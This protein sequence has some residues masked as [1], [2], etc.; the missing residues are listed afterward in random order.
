VLLHFNGNARDPR[1]HT[2]DY[3]PGH[4]VYRKATTVVKDVPAKA[5]ETVIQVED[6]RDFRVNAGRYRTSNDDLALFRIT[7]DGKHDWRYGEQV[8]LISAD[9]EANTITA[10]RGCYGTQPLRFEAGRP[11][12]GLPAPFFLPSTLIRANSAV[13]F[14]VIGD[15]GLRRLARGRRQPGLFMNRAIKFTKYMWKRSYCHLAQNAAQVSGNALASGLCDDY[16]NPRLAPCGSS[17]IRASAMA[18][19]P[20]GMPFQNLWRQAIVSFPAISRRDDLAGRASVG[21]WSSRKD[22]AEGETGAEYRHEVYRS[23]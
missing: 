11:A 15:Y 21:H 22:V 3:F 5:G 16:S 4:W 7:P 14:R 23:R 19:T 10:R 9:A 2:E 8:Q 12:F 1:Y 17:I 6:A 18:A 20:T 13:E